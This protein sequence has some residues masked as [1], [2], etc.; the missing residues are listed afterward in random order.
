MN[1]NLNITIDVSYQEPQYQSYTHLF[2]ASNFALPL[3]MGRLTSVPDSI[4]KCP[5]QVSKLCINGVHVERIKSIK[6]FAELKDLLLGINDYVS[7]CSQNDANDDLSVYRII[8]AL[9]RVNAPISDIFAQVDDLVKHIYWVHSNFQNGSDIR[10]K[11][12]LNYFEVGKGVLV[13]FQK[14]LQS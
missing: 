4:I 8:G 6:T 1:N 3:I 2:N 13:G 9:D 12:S 14:G 11:D 7:K 5:I 10:I